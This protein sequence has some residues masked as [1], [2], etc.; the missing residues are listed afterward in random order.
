MYHFELATEVK[1]LS[2]NKFIARDTDKKSERWP[3]VFEGDPRAMDAGRQK[4]D[5]KE[6][7]IFI[8]KTTMKIN[9]TNNNKVVQ[10]K[11]TKSLINNTK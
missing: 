8:Q 2:K 1:M 11:Q 5:H 10:T 3:D 9:V 6:T 4:S 7:I